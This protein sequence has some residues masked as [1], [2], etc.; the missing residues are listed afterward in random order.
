MAE[1]IVHGRRVA[2]LDQGA[3]V[4]VVL[5]DAG[6]SSG[7]Q[8]MKTASFLTNRFRVIAPDLTEPWRGEGSPIRDHAASGE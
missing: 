8:W 7:K 2:Y 5:L 3:G 6:G 4:P 1:L